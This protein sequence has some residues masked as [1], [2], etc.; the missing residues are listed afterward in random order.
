MKGRSMS[1]PEKKV[2]VTLP[3][4]PRWTDTL[5]RVQW[6]EANG[7]TDA[8]W[9]ESIAPDA[10]TTTAALGALTEN[11]RVGIAISSVFSRTP[12]VLA[13]TANALEQIMPGRFVLGLG[14]SS[15]GM[16]E[17][18]HGQTFENLFR[19]SRKPH[20]LFD[21][22]SQVKNQ[23]LMAQPSRATAIARWE[24]KALRQFI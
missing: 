4:G 18:W 12:A 17:G 2:A 8:W 23:T 13:S 1:K 7:Y 21:P 9:G 22:C 11:I 15:P 5:A 14:S 16:V 3:A 6:A 19:G 20:W 10:L 24:W